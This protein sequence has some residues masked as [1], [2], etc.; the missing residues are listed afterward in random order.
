MV[1]VISKNNLNKESDSEE[2]EEESLDGS[3]CVLRTPLSGCTFYG[4]HLEEMPA[5]RPSDDK[6]ESSKG[7]S[8]A[9]NSSSLN[10]EHK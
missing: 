7:D 10:P 3:S 6:T 2:K 9:T 5:G 4:D 1:N 8:L